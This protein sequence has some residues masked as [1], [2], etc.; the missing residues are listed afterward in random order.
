MNKPSQRRGKTKSRGLRII[1]GQ[2]R[3]RRIAVADVASLR[4]TPDRVRETVFNWIGP[5]IENA[6]CLDL[7]AGSGILGLEALS[8]GAATVDFV[9]RERTLCDAIGR[10]LDAFG[11]RGATVHC[12]DAQRYLAQA[13]LSG[14]DVVFVDPPY[15]MPLEPIID[16]LV[17]GLGSGALV[18]GERAL[19]QGLPDIDA[20]AWIRASKAGAVAFGIMETGAN[21]S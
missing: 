16:T 1:A 21:V 9:E 17:H 10:C 13:P 12:L 18:Y 14:F 5:R 6:R 2:W 15:S 4:P 11:A 7:F 20:A 3:G 8:R 19:E